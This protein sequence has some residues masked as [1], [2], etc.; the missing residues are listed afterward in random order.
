M[1]LQKRA[2]IAKMCGKANAQITVAVNSG[3]LQLTKEGYVDD[4]VPKNKALIELWKSK[5]KSK[6]VEKSIK[7]QAKKSEPINKPNVSVP[8]KDNDDTKTKGSGTYADQKLKGEIEY[9]IEQ[10]I[11]IRLK[12][13]K[14]RGESIP[15]DL[16]F[17]IIHS[18]GV[19]FQTEYKNGADALMMQYNHKHKVPSKV[20]SAL[21]LKL[22][23]LIN[24]SHKKAISN[25]KKEL[26]NIIS[27]VASKEANSTDQE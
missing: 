27:Q 22:N 16:V 7:P 8:P 24:S 5:K 17:N 12:S 25:C 2:D 3:R 10:T 14:L 13:A 1:P 9:K 23:E 11:N 6:P 15:I 21:G 19:S 26:K 20:S 4:Q 18:L